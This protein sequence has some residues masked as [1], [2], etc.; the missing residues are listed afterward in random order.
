MLGR[1]F[2][3]GI[4]CLPLEL[5][6]LGLPLGTLGLHRGLVLGGQRC[7]ANFGGRFKISADFSNPGYVGE[8]VPN[9]ENVQ[10]QS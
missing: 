2:L 6:H 8:L 5:L 9:I 10:L 3:V 4:Y 1:G 7:P